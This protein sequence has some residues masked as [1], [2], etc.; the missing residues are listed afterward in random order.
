VLSGVLPGLAGTREPR[1]DAMDETQAPTGPG[2]EPQ[3]P[4]PSQAERVLRAIRNVESG[5][6]PGAEA[7]A[8]SNEYT[9]R[10]VERLRGLWRRL[11]GRGSDA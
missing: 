6:D 8:L 2:E 9:D 3:S 4:E 1:V 5:A 10:H 7:F 11:R